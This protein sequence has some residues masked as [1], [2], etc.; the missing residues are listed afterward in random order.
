MVLL[1]AA[2]VGVPT[3][4][5]GVGHIIEWAPHAAVAVPLRD[6]DALARETTALLADDARRLRIAA[7]AQA[8]AL[9]QDADWTAR[10]VSRIYREL[11]QAPR[12]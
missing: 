9:A 12:A 10:E 11:W 8:L 3:V 5:T 4:G 1:E 7:A 2:M 6:H